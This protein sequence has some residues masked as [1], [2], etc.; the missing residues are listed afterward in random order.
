MKLIT[1]IFILILILISCQSKIENKANENTENNQTKDKTKNIIHLENV[2]EGFKVKLFHHETELEY[3]TIVTK[4]FLKDDLFTFLEF[5]YPRLDYKI[6]KNK[7]IELY[8]QKVK[9]VIETSDFKKENRNLKFDV[10]EK[11]LQKID[12][13]KIYG[14]DGNIPQKEISDF[15]ILVNRKRIEIPKDYYNDLFEPTIECLNDNDNLYCYTVGYLTEKNELIITMQNSDG[16]G[17]YMVIFF[18]DKEYNLTDRI[19]GNQ[20]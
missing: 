4:H 1:T 14:T 7:S 15:Y 8:N 9:I 13:K 3:D 11:F 16:A 18:F 6:T 2:G 19:I 17:S 5:N 20:F 12:E 10:G